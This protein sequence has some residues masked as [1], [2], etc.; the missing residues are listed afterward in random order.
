MPSQRL[1][2]A[3]KQLADRLVQWL[4]AQPFRRCAQECSGKPGGRGGCGLVDRPGQETQRVS[5]SDRVQGNERPTEDVVSGR[6]QARSQAQQV[7]GRGVVRGRKSTSV[8]PSPQPADAGE[9]DA[10]KRR[11]G[12]HCGCEHHPRQSVPGSTRDAEQRELVDTFRYASPIRSLRP[13]R[14]TPELSLGDIDGRCADANAAPIDEHRAAD[15]RDRAAELLPSFSRDDRI[16]RTAA[17][18]RIAEAEEI[19]VRLEVQAARSKTAATRAY[20]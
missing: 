2:T 4:G 8:E 9:G 5:P 10:L 1:G 7:N 16:E 19:A 11:S 20:A 6:R 18:A 14:G 12:P 3:G 15:R 13:G 17:D